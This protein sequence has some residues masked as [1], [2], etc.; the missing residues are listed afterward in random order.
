MQK[1]RNK[2]G[3]LITNFISGVLNRG[4]YWRVAGLYLEKPSSSV[5]RQR[6]RLFQRKTRR[7][8]WEKGH[9]GNKM[10]SSMINIENIANK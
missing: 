2:N 6:G 10:Q 8:C 7:P 5:D 1:A 3:F 9:G 4:W